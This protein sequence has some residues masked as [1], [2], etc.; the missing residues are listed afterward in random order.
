MYWKGNTLVKLGDGTSNT[1]AKAIFIKDDDVY[2]AG[3]AEVSGKKKAVYWKNGSMVI[4]DDGAAT[5]I[6]VQGPDVY[7]SGNFDNYVYGT[8][9]PPVMVA[10]YWKNGVINKLVNPIGDI[11]GGLPNA[12][13]LAISVSGNDVYVGGFGNGTYGG[14]NIVALYWKN[15]TATNL[16]TYSSSFGNLSAK[17]TVNDLVVQGTDI[18]MA[19]FII[20]ATG[21][22]AKPT[23]IGGAVYWKNTIGVQ[24]FDNSIYSKS[25]VIGINGSIVYTA[26]PYDASNGYYKKDNAVVM[27]GMNGQAP[28]PT[29]IAFY[30]NDVY[31]CGYGSAQGSNSGI[32]GYWKNAS[33]VMLAT[34]GAQ[35]TGI[36]VI[37]HK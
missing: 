9:V 34:S 27:L 26:G 24:L 15:G 36:V 17:S 12:N 13:A 23:D 25:S 8:S 11:S 33:L 6:V 28:N 5:D 3:S 18:Y 37:K 7:V 31:I 22:L 16:T 10:A 14:G 35:A 2:V 4:L 21:I 32:A 29:G 19:G 20:P 1:V 30:N